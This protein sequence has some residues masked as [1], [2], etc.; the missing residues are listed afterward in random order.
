MK[1]T[2]WSSLSAKNESR[3]RCSRSGQTL[4]TQTCRLYTARRLQAVVC[5]NESVNSKLAAAAK[6]LQQ[7]RTCIL[8]E[9]AHVGHAATFAYRPMGPDGRFSRELG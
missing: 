2:C 9:A 7:V 4:G 1:R 5:R 8:R 6:R 3:S